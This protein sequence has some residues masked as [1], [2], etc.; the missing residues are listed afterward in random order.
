MDAKNFIIIFFLLIF[1]TLDIVFADQIINLNLSPSEAYLKET[2]TFNIEFTSSQNLSMVIIHFYIDAKKQGVK[3]LTN[4]EKNRIY[5]VTFDNCFNEQS[6]EGEH[7]TELKID[8]ISENK[9]NGSESY[10]GSVNVYSERKNITEFL[11]YILIIPPFFLLRKFTCINKSKNDAI[12]EFRDTDRRFLFGFLVTILPISISI[13]ILYISEKP[14]LKIGILSLLICFIISFMLALYS[15]IIAEGKGEV[16]ANNSILY[17]VYFIILAL[18][19]MVVLI[20]I[21]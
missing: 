16:K 3:K 1:L 8:F 10:Y 7:Y 9:E 18:I 21:F 5:L 12:I 14:E 11:I 6:Y 19:E 4:I 13:F 2:T 20:F 17:S 15:F